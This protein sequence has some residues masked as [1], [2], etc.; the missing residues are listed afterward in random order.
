M[1]LRRLRL[2]LRMKGSM[3]GESAKDAHGPL[4][5]V[6]VD[7]AL[8]GTVIEALVSTAR[9]GSGIGSKGSGLL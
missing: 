1:D 8:S 7:G 3:P 9:R 2:D 4:E 5:L 6:V